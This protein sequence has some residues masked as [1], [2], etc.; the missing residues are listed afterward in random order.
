MRLGHRSHHAIQ[1]VA[2]GVVAF[3]AHESDWAIVT[4]SG[5][6]PFVSVCRS[7]PSAMPSNALQQRFVRAFKRV[8]DWEQAQPVS[9]LE[10]LAAMLNAEN[11]GA[12]AVLT[13]GKIHTGDKGPQATNSPQNT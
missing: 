1:P 3:S 4:I 12:S 8:E 2:P 13:A 5:V 11:I 7:G 6:T 10:R 9:S